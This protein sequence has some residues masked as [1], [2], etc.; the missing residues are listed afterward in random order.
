MAV[1]PRLPPLQDLHLPSAAHPLLGPGRPPD[2]LLPHNVALHTAPRCLQ[3]RPHQ[4]PPNRTPPHRRRPS[5]QGLL[6]RR[7]SLPCEH[8]LDYRNPLSSQFIISISVFAAHYTYTDWL[9]E[10]RAESLSSATLRFLSLGPPSPPPD[11]L[12]EYISSTRRPSLAQVLTLATI[13]QLHTTDDSTVLLV[14][15]PHTDSTCHA[16]N[17]PPPSLDPP[18]RVYV[19]ML[20]R[21][22]ILHT[23]YSTTSCL[24]GVSRTL[25]MLRHFYWWIGRDIS[26]R[27][28]LRP[29]LNHQARLTSC[30]TIRWSTL[31]SPFPNG[32]GILVSVNYSGSLPLTLLSNAC[33]LLFTD[34]FSRRADMYATTEAQ[35]TTSGTTDILVDRYISL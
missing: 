8:H 27:W 24:L 34:R 4:V 31:S 6:P 9:C 35:F 1:G 7:P 3:P 25:S 13:D 30:H 23:C 2:D 21:P 16:R 15:R 19:S 28:W 17:P 12:L 5:I 32:P 14:H 26:T 33:I 18:H 10:Q 20:M 22:W 29:C 11:D